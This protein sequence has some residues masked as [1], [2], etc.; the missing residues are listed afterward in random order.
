MSDT[1]INLEN[2]S[3]VYCVGEW[4]T[5][6]ISHS[7]SRHDG[8]LNMWWKTSNLRLEDPYLNIVQTND[9]IQKVQKRE[10]L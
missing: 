10:F 7:L 4:G 1:V 8:N 3:K 5:G 6:T 9:R 2:L